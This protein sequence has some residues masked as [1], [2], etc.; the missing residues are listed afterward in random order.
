MD[1]QALLRPDMPIYSIIINTAIWSWRDLPTFE[2]EDIPFDQSPQQ[3]N[4][5]NVKHRLSRLST[6]LPLCFKGVK[7]REEDSGKRQLHNN[8]KT[9]RD[10]QP[11]KF[12]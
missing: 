12:I 5:G 6:Q 2:D 4:C 8:Q 3:R 11:A 10:H 1:L 9:D 7:K